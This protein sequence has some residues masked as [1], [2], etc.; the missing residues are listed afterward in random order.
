M[1]EFKYYFI[2]EFN[3]LGPKTNSISL[4]YLVNNI[5]KPSEVSVKYNG[6]NKIYTWNFKLI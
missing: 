3:K 5:K 4:N 2:L 1:N 6:V